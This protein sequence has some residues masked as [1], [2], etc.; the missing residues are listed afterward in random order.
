[1]K[2]IKMKEKENLKIQAKRDEVTGEASLMAI[3]TVFTCAQTGPCA[4]RDIHAHVDTST[5]P[6]MHNE[7]N[8]KVQEKQ[9][10]KRIS[11]H[12]HL[13]SRS[14]GS[15]VGCSHRA[16]ARPRVSPWAPESEKQCLEVETL[17]WKGGPSSSS[18][19]FPGDSRGLLAPLFPVMSVTDIQTTPKTL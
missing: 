15:A 9:T 2:Y 1:M 19:F 12:P 3:Y 7:T 13:V 18:Y 16:C 14:Y 4:W 5:C 17:A 8:G 11:S 10:Y 6:V